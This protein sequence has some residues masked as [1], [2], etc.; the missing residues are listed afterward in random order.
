MFEFFLKGVDPKEVIDTIARYM[1]ETLA[2]LERIEHK[3]DEILNT[4]KE[5]EPAND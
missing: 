1:R 5:R 4:L 2:S 3:Q